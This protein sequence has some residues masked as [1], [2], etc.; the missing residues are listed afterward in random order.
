MRTKEQSLDILS[1]YAKSRLEKESFIFCIAGEVN[2]EGKKWGIYSLADCTTMP[3]HRGRLFLRLQSMESQ[4]REEKEVW[5]DELDEESL[6]SIIER[7]R[8][9]FKDAFE[10]FI[11]KEKGKPTVQYEQDWDRDGYLVISGAKTLDTY[12]ELCQKEY[13][14][15]NPEI[16]FAFNDEG[17]K[18]KRKELGLEDKE[19][20]HYGG[21]LCGTKEGLKKFTEDMEAIREEKRKKCDPYEVY[22]YEYNNHES[23]ISWDGDLEPARIIVRIWGKETLDSIK[24]LNKYENQ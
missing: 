6:N 9:L 3:E 7:S 8:V 12:K 13:E 20:F 24:R 11:P 15:N 5:L 16:F 10:P 23:F 18:E 4:D 2:Y 17:V 22:L 1:R 14:Y 19:V 21:G